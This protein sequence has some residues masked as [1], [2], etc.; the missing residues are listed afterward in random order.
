MNGERDWHSQDPIYMPSHKTDIETG[1]ATCVERVAME[2]SEKKDV[3]VVSTEIGIS[4]D[5]GV[6]SRSS[7]LLP[8]KPV[9]KLP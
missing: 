7:I 4:S 1:S 9:L 5:E 2:E 6:P 3:V 8:P